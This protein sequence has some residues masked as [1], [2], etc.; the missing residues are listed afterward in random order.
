[1]T[2]V[3]SSGLMSNIGEYFTVQ[4]YD[5]LFDYMER[6]NVQAGDKLFTQGENV[7]M[8]YLIERG[9][10][11]VYRELNDG[12]R[13]RLRRMGAGMIV[14]ET[15][16]YLRSQAS[17]TVTADI[18]SELFVLT[19][20][21]LKR[22]EHTQPELAAKFHRYIIQMLGQRLQNMNASVQALLE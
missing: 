16:M 6:R 5:S 20:E 8:L 22:M 4:E 11:T 1:M 9:L 3:T 14:G 12:R 17:A 7:S 10:V 15:G 13:V 18:N 2:V 19:D 21:G